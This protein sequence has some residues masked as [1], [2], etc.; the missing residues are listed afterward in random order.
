M[1]QY[2]EC[3][4]G[5]LVKEGNRFINGHNMKG[6]FQPMYNKHHSEETKRE[7]IISGFDKEYYLKKF[8]KEDDPKYKEQL[9][10]R[11]E[12]YYQ[13][14][15]EREEQCQQGYKEYM[16]QYHKQHHREIAR[17]GREHRA[18]RRQLGFCPL[19]KPF[20]DCEGH[21]I[22]QNFIIYLPSEIH[23]SIWHSIWTWQGMEE[24]NR[25]AIEFL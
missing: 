23:K 21:H 22:S 25:L 5:A 18:K 20:K 13:E 10:K 1:K 4:C 9:A 3:G 15:K 19:N 6:K 17:T 8:Q 11:A 14:Y 24:M 16:E 12:K 2:C 7:V